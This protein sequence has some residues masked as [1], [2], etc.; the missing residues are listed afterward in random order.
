MGESYLGPFSAVGRVGVFLLM[1]G[2]W[3]GMYLSC[4]V[5]V[6]WRHSITWHQLTWSLAAED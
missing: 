1:G 5:H 6:R 3:G 2:F 4:G